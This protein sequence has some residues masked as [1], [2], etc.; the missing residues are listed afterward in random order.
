MWDAEAKAYD[1]LN[2]YNDEKRFKIATPQ[3][4]FRILREHTDADLTPL[5]KKYFSG[6]Y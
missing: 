5:I 1:I 4:F 2:K 6:N 3:D